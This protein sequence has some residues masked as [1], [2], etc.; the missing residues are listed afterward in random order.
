MTRIKDRYQQLTIRVSSGL[1][2]VIFLV[3][4]AGC[5][6]N[7]KQRVLRLAHALD[8]K[9]SVHLAMVKLGERL[10]ELSDGKMSVQIYPNQQLGSER[11]LLELIQ[12]GSIDITKVSGSV[13]ENF[14]PQYRV[15]SVP[16]L[17][18]NRQHAFDVLDGEVG[19]EL[20]NSGKKYWL[21]G[22][23]FYDSGS[24]SFYTKDKPILKPEDL[25]GMKIRTQRSPSAMSMVRA[26]GGAATPIPFGEL[27]TALQA[28]VVDG[29]E[30]N[31][32]S[33]YLTKHYEICKYYSI[34][35]HTTIPDVLLMSTHIFDRLNSQEK[36]WLE[37]A[38]SESVTYQRQLWNSSEKEALEAVRKA[39]VEVIYPDKPPFYDKLENLI[40]E[41]R[42]D[43][44]IAKLITKIQETE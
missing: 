30:N 17:F 43:E 4:F 10:T 13:M 9:H 32:P 40:A 33:F 29:A 39:G 21:Q 35:E 34:D 37:Q 28:G 25:E 19:K 24:R 1:F 2:L 20:L 8:E 36:K 6:Q 14:A 12:I 41:F 31:P 23:G 7:K 27:Y 11:E 42:Q 44:L 5:A 3:L 15:L 22:L 38:V 26:L 18:K 16:Y